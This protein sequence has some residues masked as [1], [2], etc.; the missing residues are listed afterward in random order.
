VSIRPPLFPW[1]FH[2]GLVAVCAGTAGVDVGTHNW[3]GLPLMAAAGGMNGY[4]GGRAFRR[5]HARPRP[6]YARIRE[7]EIELGMRE[8]PL[9]LP[10]YSTGLGPSM[11]LSPPVPARPQWMPGP[12]HDPRTPGPRHPGEAPNP[13]VAGGMT[14]E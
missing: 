4:A 8:A 2:A 3:W 7:L 5:R 14:Y 9:R 10:R 6:D 13:N 12:E 11:F 1:Q